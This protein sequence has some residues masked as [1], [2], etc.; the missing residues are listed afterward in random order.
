MTVRESVEA[1]V[2]R[3]RPAL[4]ADG[5]DLELVAFD[6]S[7]ARVRLLGACAGCPAASM[8]LQ[9]GVEGALRRIHPDI[10]VVSV[11]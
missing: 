8:T 9:A 2:E 1:I 11:D 6:G 10:S 3:I 7:I 4:N 5:G